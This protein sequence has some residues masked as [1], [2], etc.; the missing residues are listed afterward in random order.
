MTNMHLTGI[1]NSQLGN[2]Q[3]ISLLISGR[4]RRNRIQLS[5]NTASKR[6]SVPE[7]R[8]VGIRSNNQL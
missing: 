2:P 3:L 5:Y 1:E 6:P 8:D 7:H 4:Y